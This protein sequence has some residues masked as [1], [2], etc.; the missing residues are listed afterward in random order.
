MAAA[1]I[2][3]SSNLTQLRFIEEAAYGVV[4]GTG[5]ASNIRNTGD[6]LV[7]A[8]N[9]TES[10]E[11][12]SDRMTTDLVTV[13]ASASGGLNFELSYK[14]FDKLILAALMDQD[15][16]YYGV[17]TP[18]VGQGVGTA[19][20]ATFTATVLTAG[21]APTG[22]SDFTTLKP[23]QWF[24]VQCAGSANDKKWFRI[25]S[26][27]PVTT[28]TITVDPATPF[29]LDATAKS[30][31]LS[32]SRTYNGVYQTQF[33]FERAHNDV[34]QFFRFYGMTL[35]KMTL[36]LSSGAIVTGSFEFMGKNGDRAT[37]TVMPGTPISSQTYDVMNAVSGVGQILE[38]GVALAAKIKK[39]DLSIDNTLRG[40]DAIGVL[41]NAGIGMGSLKITGSMDVYLAD[42][43]LY[44]KF[45]NNT[46]SSLQFGVQDGAKNGYMFQ[47]PNLKYGDA[48]VT[49]GNKDADCMISIPFTGLK[50]TARQAVL[51][52]DRL[53]V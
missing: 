19:F 11:I 45:V 25:H 33:T 14:E 23:G 5:N 13:G 47:I 2:G 20:Q 43:T 17:S 10:G 49:A 44:D 35:S 37:A 38:G 29:T 8:L 26:T 48:K 21:T 9:K 6:S 34:T 32:S 4:P 52:V 24:Q 42:G 50:D 12:V 1:L 36:S 28:T 27:T 39:L 22:T 18:G 16:D 30:A 31:K 41:G 3:G 15:F 7:F 46:A 40:Q 51:L 53:G